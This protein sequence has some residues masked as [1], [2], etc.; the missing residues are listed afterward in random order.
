MISTNVESC[1]PLCS[2][3]SSSVHSHY[4]RT[5]SDVPCAGQQIQLCL[6]VQRFYCHNSLCERKIFTERMP[7]FVKPWAR[8]T[9]RLCQALQS[10]GL[11]TNIN[12]RMSPN[13]DPFDSVKSD[14]SGDFGHF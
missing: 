6:M 2:Q 14:L 10:I 11:A 7:R 4:Q 3:A 13:S 12:L 1:C 8:M 9:I 5:L